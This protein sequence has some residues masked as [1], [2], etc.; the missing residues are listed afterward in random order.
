VREKITKHLPK[1]Y[2]F[3]STLTL[4]LAIVNALPRV[5]HQRQQTR[6][7][8]FSEATI[9][10][11]LRRMRSLHAA[12]ANVNARVGCCLPLFLAAGE[13]RLEAVRY[14]LDEGADVNAR[15]KSVAT[16]LTEATYYGRL[17]VVKELLF[18]DAD[19]NT[20][21]DDGTALDIA[22]KRKYSVIADVL[23]HH[24]AKKACE[25]TKCN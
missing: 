17:E 14:L 9:D 7:R 2:A 21:S 8:L 1:L 16:A 23:R 19:V 15:E 22:M 10:G 6:Q 18:H 4:S 11:D 12:G 5:R 3:A 25:L 20:I 13:G 24:G